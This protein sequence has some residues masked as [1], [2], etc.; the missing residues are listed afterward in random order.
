MPP[1]KTAILDRD[2][3]INMDSSEFIKSPD[4]WTAIPGSLEAIAKLNHAGWRVVVATNQSGLARG[5]F[6]MNTLTDIHHKMHQQVTAL[7]GRID[8]IFICPHGPHDGCHC[9][10]PLPG[11]F[12]DI[13]RRYELNLRHCV[14]VGDSLRDLEAAHSTGC[15]TALVLTGNGAKTQQHTL[16]DGCSIHTDLAAVVDYWLNNY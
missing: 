13:A 14:S 4:E 7:G 15:Q 2:G 3:V 9:R 8:S 6:D 1:V 5:L 11:L 10:K 12:L 16:P